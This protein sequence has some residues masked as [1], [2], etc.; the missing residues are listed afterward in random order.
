[1]S[2]FGSR[3]K[4]IRKTK[5]ITQKD[6]AKNIQVAQ[7]T[8]ANYE[9]NIR[10]PGS[11]ILRQISDYLMISVDYLLGLTELEKTDEISHNYK[12]ETVYL[13]LVDILMAG[14]IEEAKKIIMNFFTS[15]KTSI[16]II[17]YIFIP[18]LHL[19][20]EKW[21]KDEIDIGQEHYITELI[22]RLFDYISEKQII[23]PSKD[24]TALFMAPTGE[25]HTIS[26][27]MS[28]EYFRLNGWSILFI[29]RSIPIQSL[30]QT[31][32]KN[33]VDLLVLSAITQS[34]INSASYLV[35]AINSNLKENAP[36]FLLGGNIGDLSNQK[37]LNTFIDYSVGSIYELKERIEKI[38][39]DILN[40]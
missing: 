21:E 36:K 39:N 17:E 40:R 34:S 33:K 9:N 32:E 37:T 20:G 38:E 30:L 6:L 22:D 5:N 26:L 16:E 27:K 28:T 35:E 12:L 11:E 19:I 8:I 2:D 31:I 14:E 24:L 23:G 3:L 13:Y 25:E 4:H 18:M 10:F 7:S 15:G 29:G 1:M